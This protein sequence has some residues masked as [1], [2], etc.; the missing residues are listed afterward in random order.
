MSE[1]STVSRKSLKGKLLQKSF[2]DQAFHVT[3]TPPNIGSL[4]SLHRILDKYLDHMLVKLTQNRMVRDVQNSELFD[5][6]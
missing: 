1:F 5:K 3:I 6:C 2:I 4:K